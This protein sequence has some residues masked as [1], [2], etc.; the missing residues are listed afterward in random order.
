MCISRRTCSEGHVA[1]HADTV[2]HVAISR[3][4]HEVGSGHSLPPDLPALHLR[5]PAPE[6]DQ[7]VIS[8]R[9]AEALLTHWAAFTQR[10]D[11]LVDLG[12]LGL[13]SSVPPAAH[14]RTAAWS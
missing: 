11:G 8:Q 6:P 13:N 12:V 7:R 1:T 9:H 2:S 14:D 10:P 3:G 4:F 5:R